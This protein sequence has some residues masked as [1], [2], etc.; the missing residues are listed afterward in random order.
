[1]L[2][3]RTP[4][5]VSAALPHVLEHLA[6]DRLIAYPTET[7]YGFGGAITPAAAQRLR[8]LKRREAVKPFL[9]LIHSPEQVAGVQWDE[10]ARA[11]AARLW[12]GPVTLVLAAAADAFPEGIV[13]ADGTV[14]VRASP[15]PLVAALTA[16]AGPITSTSANAPGTS[17]ARAAAEVDRALYSLGAKDVLVL[18]GGELP[19]SAP[20]T[21]LAVS[22]GRARIVRAGAVSGDQLRERLAGTGIDVSG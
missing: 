3:V 21:I 9:L 10:T 17:P 20:S 2:P 15:H 14:A 4:A 16:V 22:D 5:Q 19:E 18:D 12:P 13:A 6:A 8:D 11:L 1:M 7:V